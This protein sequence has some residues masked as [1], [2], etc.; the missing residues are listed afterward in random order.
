M[1]AADIDAMD[2]TIAEM[3]SIG[4]VFEVAGAGSTAVLENVN[5]NRN[6]IAQ[7]SPMNLWVGINVR[8]SGFG[9]ISNSTFIDNTNIRHI[10]STFNAGTL[11]VQNLKVIG[12]S[13]G[14][15]VVSIN[16]VDF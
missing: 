15:V 10:F 2:V 5:I 8:D 12:A 1:Q 16:F 9:V 7:S 11:E 6:N 14:R 13:G 4:S 3:S